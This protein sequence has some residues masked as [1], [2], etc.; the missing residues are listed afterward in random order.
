MPLLGIITAMTTP[1]GPDGALGDID[2]LE[3]LTLEG[4]AS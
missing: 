2:C 1:V 3:P 4:N